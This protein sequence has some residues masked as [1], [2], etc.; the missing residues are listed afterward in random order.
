MALGNDDNPDNGPNQN[1]FAY[2]IIPILGFGLVVAVITCYRYRRKKQQLARLAEDPEYQRQLEEGRRHGAHA[3]VRGPNGVVIIADDRGGRRRGAGGRSRRLGLGAGMGSREEGLN[4]LGEAPPAYT[5]NAPKPPSE[6]GAEHIELT[7]Y[8]Q[9]T[10]EAGMS[11]SPPLYGELLPARPRPTSGTGEMGVSEETRGDVPRNTT[12]SHTGDNTRA[13]E[14]TSGASAPNATASGA[15][16]AS[17]TSEESR[18]DSTR[19]A[20]SSTTTGGTTTTTSTTATT[21][22]PTPPPR[23]V[24]PSS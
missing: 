20:T 7:T 4:E 19:N 15:S 16:N 6:A 5:P 8:S 23:A 12:T 3:M 18:E 2:V 22:E 9:A 14:E 21:E 10:A 24:L 1:P 11:R 13:S 17:G